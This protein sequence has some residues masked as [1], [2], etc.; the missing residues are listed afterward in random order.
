MSKTNEQAFPISP[1]GH[2]DAQGVLFWSHGSLGLTKREYF[3]AKA[4]QG[5]LSIPPKFLEETWTVQ[6]I[7][8]GSVRWADALLA[9]LE[10]TNGT[11]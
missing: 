8:R 4:M 10:K 7:A 9:E 6:E 2:R 1:G 5:I 3:A 11:T